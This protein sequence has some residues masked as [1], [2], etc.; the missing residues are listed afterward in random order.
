MKPPSP[1]EYYHSLQASLELQ[2][3]HS[4]R[5]L[6]CE[7]GGLLPECVRPVADGRVLDVACGQGE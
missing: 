1:L 2:L 7:Q 5:A 4:L 3:L 6:L